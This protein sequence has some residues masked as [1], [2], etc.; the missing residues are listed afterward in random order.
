M[1][2]KDTRKKNI[3]KTWKKMP[4]MVK[5]FR[6]KWRVIRRRLWQGKKEDIPN[7]RIKWKSVEENKMRM[8]PY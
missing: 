1:S 8:V 5:D 6:Y 2:N 7:F 4:G 3:L